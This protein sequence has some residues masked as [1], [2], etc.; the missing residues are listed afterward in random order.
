[1]IKYLD[2]ENGSIL[3]FFFLPSSS[4]RKRPQSNRLEV[5]FSSTFCSEEKRIANRKKKRNNKVDTNA[6][7]FDVEKVFEISIFS[8]LKMRQLRQLFIRCGFKD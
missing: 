7:L 1:M 3:H 5:A 2:D 4:Q 6:S 8:K